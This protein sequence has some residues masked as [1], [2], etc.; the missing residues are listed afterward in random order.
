VRLQALNAL[1][2]LPADTVRPY[3]DVVDRATGYPDEY[4]ANA[5]RYSKAVLAGT[6][7]PLAPP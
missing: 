4:V 5:A 3:A 2:Y 7:D 6:Y 1:T